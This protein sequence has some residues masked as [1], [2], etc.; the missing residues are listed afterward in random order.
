MASTSARQCAAIAASFAVQAGIVVAIV[1]IPAGNAASSASPPA[2]A[3]APVTPAV[4]VPEPSAPRPG[5]A[6]EVT[7]TG[8]G[9]K[10]YT[11]YPSPVEPVLWVPPASQFALTVTLTIPPD[12]GLGS[13]RLGITNGAWAAVPDHGTALVISGKPPPGEHIYTLH[14]TAADLPFMNGNYLVLTGQD[15]GDP[16]LTAPLAE[17]I[18]APYP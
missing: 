7:V 13:F 11:E 18:V 8:A 14:L 5:P 9:Q 15:D 2:P 16:A 17:L 10:G 12:S 4:S 6:I 1:A 3:V